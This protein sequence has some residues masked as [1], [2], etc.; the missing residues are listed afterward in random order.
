MAKKRFD[1]VSFDQV[2]NDIN[3]W[4]DY[5]NDDENDL[6][7]LNAIDSEKEDVSISVDASEEVLIEEEH[8]EEKEFRAEEVQNHHG[9]V[10]PPKKQLTKYRFVNS[11]DTSLNQENF[12]QLVYLNKHGNFETFTGYMGHVK[13]PKTESIPGK[14]PAK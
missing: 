7:D 5:E 12:E 11:I 1:A 4:L 8:E 2:M 13:D 9:R 3:C 6:H 14:W 10:G